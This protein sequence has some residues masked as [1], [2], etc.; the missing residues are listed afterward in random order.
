MKIIKEKHYNMDCIT[1]SQG[2]L[3]IKMLPEL[4]FKM[5]SIRYKDKEFLFQPSKKEYMKA[6]Y[7]DNFVDYDTSGLDEMIPTI[8]SCILKGNTLLPDHGDVWSVPWEVEIKEDSVIGV[9][10]LRSMDLK[11]EKTVSMVD[12]NTITMKYRLINESEKK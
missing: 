5:S 10:D 8:D 4:G 12:S 11:F 6:V 9:V 7:G 3:S 2:G 1:L